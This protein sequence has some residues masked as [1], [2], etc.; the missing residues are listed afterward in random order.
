LER[1]LVG[2]KAH[3]I[4]LEKRGYLAMNVNETPARQGRQEPVRQLF[5]LLNGVGKHPGLFRVE[6]HCATIVKRRM[7]KN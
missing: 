2:K 6:R 1:E 3:D 5:A 7:R 4:K